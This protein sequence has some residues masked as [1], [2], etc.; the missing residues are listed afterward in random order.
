MRLTSSVNILDLKAGIPGKSKIKKI[1]S[2]CFECT[3]S[4]EWFRKL[5]MR[6]TGL[7]NFTLNLIMKLTSTINMSARMNRN[8]KQEYQTNL[9]NH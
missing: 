7:L 1:W 8:S 6:N 4:W 9:L 2:D 3:K 5:Y